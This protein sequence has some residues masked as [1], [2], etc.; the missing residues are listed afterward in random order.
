MTVVM[1]SDLYGSETF[2]AATLENAINIIRG[3]KAAARTLHDK[4]ERS[5]TIELNFEEAIALQ[6]RITLAT[7]K[8]GG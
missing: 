4:I 6:G 8:K 5:F 2:H 3:L 7:T 1:T